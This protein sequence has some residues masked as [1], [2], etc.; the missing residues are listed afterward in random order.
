MQVT[1]DLPEDLTIKLRSYLEEH[2][3]ESL[4]VILEDA[5][6][7]RSLPHRPEALLELAGIVTE[8]P[9]DAADR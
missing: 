5:L 6:L 1:F 7:R 8:A 2:P 3:Q 4:A 9:Y